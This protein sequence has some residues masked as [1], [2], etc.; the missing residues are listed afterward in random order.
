MNPKTSRRVTIEELINFATRHLGADYIFWC[1]EEP[2]YSKELIP[3]FNN[4]ANPL[5]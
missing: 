3:Y 5:P 1:T 4:P 2:F